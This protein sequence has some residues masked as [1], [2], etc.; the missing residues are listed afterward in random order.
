MNRRL[1]TNHWTFQACLIAALL[2]SFGAAAPPSA[3]EDDPKQ[4]EKPKAKNKKQVTPKDGDSSKKPEKRAKASSSGKKKPG[5]DQ[6]EAS[7]KDAEAT[8]PR[9]LA[10]RGMNRMIDAAEFRDYAFED[11][12]EWIA[13]ETGANVITRWPVIEEAGYRRDELLNIKAEKSRMRDIIPFA[14]EHLNPIGERPELACFAD[15]NVLIISTRQDIN[16]RRIT[17]V[18]FVEDLIILVPH[19]EGI[20]GNAGE[21]NI[22]KK[23]K[24]RS[25]PKKS[26]EIKKLLDTVT[27][28]IE[29]ES[30][31]RF[32]GQGTIRYYNGQIVVY[33]S[34]EVHQR[35]AGAVAASS[36]RR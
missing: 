7:G 15:D 2:L 3:D 35:L 9:N 26:E 12:I 14:F 20:S 28:H 30:W 27:K 33:N 29:P 8:A 6:S 23:K 19:F 4:A 36:S 18:Y 16:Q 11:F 31:K 25:E 17:R 5:A 34:I 22:Q 24:N 32:G 13:R 21:I 10:V 1:V